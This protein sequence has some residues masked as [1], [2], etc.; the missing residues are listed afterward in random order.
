MP[1]LALL[2]GDLGLRS[3]RRRYASLQGRSA[4]RAQQNMTLHFRDEYRG[5]RAAHQ[6]PTQEQQAP[7]A[8]RPPDAIGENPIRQAIA[9]MIGMD[10]ARTGRVAVAQSGTHLPPARVVG[11]P[12]T[13]R[14]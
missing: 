8:S 12:G 6:G 10:Y 1:L 5:A 7:H 2:R 13:A 14:S 4:S 11:R 3:G 9:L